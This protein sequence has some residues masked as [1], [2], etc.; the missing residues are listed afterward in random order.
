MEKKLDKICKLKDTI[1]G[2][3][4]WLESKVHKA[5]TFIVI[6]KTE[7]LIK[8]KFEDGPEIRYKPDII[9]FNNDIYEY[10]ISSL[11]KELV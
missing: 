7:N 9:N 8:V 5:L 4:Y 2:Q 3:R 10:P 1:I 11:E 6:Q